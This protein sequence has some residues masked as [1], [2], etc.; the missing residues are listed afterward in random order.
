VAGSSGGRFDFDGV[1]F[2]WTSWPGSGDTLVLVHHGVGE[3]GGR[4]EVLADAL[5]GLPL[6]VATYDMRGHGRSGGPKGDA[7]G[8]PQLAAD[9]EQ[10]LPRIQEATGARRVI[11]YGHSLGAGVVAWALLRGR[12]Q[13]R[14]TGAVLSAPPVGVHRNAAAHVKVAVGRILRFVSPGLRLANEI[15][16]T[17]L[18]H[19]DG[20]VARYVS[21]PLV[22]DRISLRLGLSVVDDGPL[23]LADAGRI[24]VPCLVFVGSDD[25]VV[26]AAA[27]ERFGRA[28]GGPEPT[29]A[30]LSGCRHEPHFERPDLQQ[31]WRDLVRSWFERRVSPS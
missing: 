8:L 12:L 16:P 31:K 14:V 22:H 6:T 24:A 26:D 2:A 25:R 18:S 30:L 28:V 15:D 10:M 3:H 11:I 1:S 4:W 21:D 13:E 23:L 17:L 29:F 19:D 5:A 9:L 20:A 7:E 27:A